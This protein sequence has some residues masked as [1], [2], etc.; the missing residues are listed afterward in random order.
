MTSP[1]LM[2]PQVT[3]SRVSNHLFVN[4]APYA[5]NSANPSSLA[6]WKVHPLTK[7]AGPKHKAKQPYHRRIR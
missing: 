4:K 1:R 7:N 6:A 2:A 3:Y 5:G